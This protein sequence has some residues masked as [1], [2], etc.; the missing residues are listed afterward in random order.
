MAY[1]E[2]KIVNGKIYYYLTET[3]R[4]D[5]K[6][7]KTRKYLGT[8]I[9]KDLEILKK[10]TKRIAKKLTE[11]EIRIIGRIKKNYLKK[12]RLDKTL[13]KTERERIVSFIYN[14]NAI[15]GNTLTL[16]ETDSILAGKEILHKERKRDIK[17]VQNMEKCID[18]LFDYKGEI[19][20]EMI[21]KLHYIEQKEIMHDAGKYRNVNVRV[22]NYLCPQWQEL[23][24]LMKEFIEW[25]NIAKKQLR[26]FELAALVHLKFVRIHPF[27]DGN[28]R[29]SRLLMNF[30]LL[31]GNCPLLNI[32]NDEKMLYY[33]V[34]QK[35]DFDRKERAFIRY[36]FEVFVKQYKEY[37]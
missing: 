25:Y 31:K 5:G 23:P 15:E 3:K 24:Q 9:P 14:T 13:W 11:E 26:S 20:E 34:L 1:I 6:F 4:V 30:V 33:L 37:L 29:M 35:F 16:E 8:T 36:L 27:R 28:G 22:G 32:F 10:K 12:Y 7:K 19:N 17:E 21:L 18:F 2:K